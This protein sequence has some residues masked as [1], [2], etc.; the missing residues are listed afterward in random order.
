M[1]I[2]NGTTIHQS[3]IIHDDIVDIGKNCWI[4]ENVVIGCLS[5]SLLADKNGNITRKE[6]KGRVIIG[7]NV[8]ID[9]DTAIARGVISDTTIGIGS[10]IGTKCTI[11][12]DVKIGHRCK[13]LH[14]TLICG[15]TII[16]DDARINPGV[17]ISN[18][19]IVGK[20]ST[21]GIGS[22]VIHDVP[23]GKTAFGHP[24]RVRTLQGSITKLSKTRIRDD[25]AERSPHR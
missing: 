11:G 24:A 19:I 8:T 5:A 7:D 14:H 22:L 17:L 2:G 16:G 15:H 6:F 18:R 13:V 12:H 21:V 20:K 9:T 4:G 1:T 23:D 25:I 10:Y 3:A